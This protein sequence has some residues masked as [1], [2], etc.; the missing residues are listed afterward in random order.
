[1]APE[2]N[3]LPIT[4]FPAR[5]RA[6]E[7]LPPLSPESEQFEKALLQGRL[8]LQE[9]F[10]CMRL[11]NPP[12]PVCPW[13]CTSGHIWRSV[14]GRGRVHSW[15]C[16]HRAMHPV[17]APL[18]PYVVVCVE[19]EEGPWLVGRLRDTVDTRIG[20]RVRAVIER[21]DDGVPVPAFTI[22]YP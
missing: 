3:A 12:A 5:G 22:D 19:L 14:S 9:C 17:F 4:R 13:C 18:V 10:Q 11:R 1:M 15:V 21:W 6:R 7:L 20:Q 2:S 16:Y 8:E